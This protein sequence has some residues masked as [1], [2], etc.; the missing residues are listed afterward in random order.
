MVERNEKFIK[1]KKI[2]KPRFAVIYGIIMFIATCVFVGWVLYDLWWLPRVETGIPILG[3]RMDDIPDI[4]EIWLSRAVEFGNNQ[5]YTDYVD[6]FWNE[7]PVIYFNIRVLEETE[8]DDA[9]SVAS[10]IVEYLIEIS[11]Q[12]VLYYNLQA[13]I[14]YGDIAQRRTE[15]QAAVAYHVHEYNWSLTEAILAHAEEYP[16]RGNVSRADQNLNTFASSIIISAGEEELERM[17]A[18]HEE[19]TAWTDEQEDE[20]VEE[21]GAIPVYGDGDVRQVPPSE[22]SE[23]PNWGTWSNQHERMIWS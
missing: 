23:F 21:H 14:S 6:I 15:N 2:R 16:S 17:Q 9:R 12:V 10:D 3:Y 7:G 13:V 4:D 11:N 18:R 20:W 8:L 19:I 5:D 1:R 22:I